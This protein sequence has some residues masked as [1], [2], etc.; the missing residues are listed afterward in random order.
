MNRPGRTSREQITKHVHQVRCGEAFFRVDE[1]TQV[2]V[3]KPRLIEQNAPSRQVRTRI[4]ETETIGGAPKGQETTV[5][6]D[7]TDESL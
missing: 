2:H 3:Y 7:G 6:L 4:S 1:A 5:G